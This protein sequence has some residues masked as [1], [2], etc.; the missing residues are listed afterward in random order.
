M[1]ITIFS[2]F[3]VK[4]VKGLLIYLKIYYLFS[5][6]YKILI[7]VILICEKITNLEQLVCYEK[8]R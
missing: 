7:S 2:Y 8:V 3:E 1:E 4:V 5:L 6:C